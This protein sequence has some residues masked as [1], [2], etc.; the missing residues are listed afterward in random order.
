MES[1]CQFNIQRLRLPS[2]FNYLC[3][4]SNKCHDEESDSFD[5]SEESECNSVN[6]ED[7]GDID[8]IYY[9]TF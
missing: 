6:D 3:S 9:D 1:A 4:T 5:D 2:D 7:I 8:D